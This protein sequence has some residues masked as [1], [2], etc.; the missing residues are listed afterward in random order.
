MLNT[1]LR[2]GHEKAVILWAFLSGYAATWPSA[3]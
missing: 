1:R 3:T 2:V